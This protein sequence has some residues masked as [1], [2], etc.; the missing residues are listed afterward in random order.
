MAKTLSKLLAAAS[1]GLLVA[2]AV[3]EGDAWLLG[4]VALVPLLV[5]SEHAARLRE[6]WWLGWTAGLAANLAGL[7]WM[8]GLLERYG[9]LPWHWAL[10]GYVGLCA[11]QGLVFALFALLTRLVRLRVTLRGRSLPLALV[12]P[13]VMVACELPLPFVFPWNLALTQAWVVPVIQVAELGGPFA[14]T[15]LLMVV[16]GALA[17]A[18]HERRL[19]PLLGASLV[20]L[21]ALG[22][23][24]LRLAEVEAAESRAPRLAVGVVQGN[25]SAADGANHEQALPRLATLQRESARLARAGAE[26]L[27]WTETAYPFSLP[28]ALTRDLPADYP[29]HIRRGFDTPLVFGAAS[30]DGARQANSAFFLDAQGRIAGRHDKNAL[31]AFGESVPFEE[32]LPSLKRL[33][34][35]AAG[36]Y[37]AGRE[38]TAFTLQRAGMRVRIAPLICL[39]DILPELGR[40]AGALHPQLLVNLTNDAWFGPTSEPVQHLALAVFR[41]VEQRV[42]MVRAVNTGPSAF[43]S[44][45]GRVLLRTERSRALDEQR[46]AQTLSGQV[47]LLEGGHTLYARHGNLFAQLCCALLALTLCA[48]CV[49]GR[50]RRPAVADLA[51]ALGVQ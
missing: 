48:A 16:N 9:A 44:A 14:V 7:T 37:D 21:T 26:L 34:L 43:I 29:A 46:P 27:L 25:V 42:A 50:K 32:Q 47:A 23:G 20:L 22:Y 36:E 40:R 2:L 4:W 1:S 10:L 39:E 24:Q 45:T 33:R 41:S 17:S 49:S 15:A 12:A 51:T 28:Q 31:V 3:P 19:A 18:L 30:F 38:V 8:V 13:I 5:A 6:A 11:Y 35:A